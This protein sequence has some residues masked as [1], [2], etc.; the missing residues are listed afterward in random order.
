MCR[1]CHQKTWPH[2]YHFCLSQPS[3]LIC[4]VCE[5]EF[6]AEF[7]RYRVHMRT[8]TGANPY[9]C[10]A[11]GC[12]KAYISRQL[13]WKHQIRRHPEIAANASKA[14]LEKRNKREIAKF[15]AKSLENIQLCRALVEDLLKSVIVD[16]AKPEADE[17]KPEE[18]EDTCKI[19]E[20][21]ENQDERP[22]TPPP[23]L[24][25]SL[26]ESETIEEYDPIDA[27][28]R[29]IM[30]PEGT[31]RSNRSPSK[32]PLSPS[33]NDFLRPPPVYAPTDISEPP[34]LVVNTQSPIVQL[35][36]NFIRGPLPGL[37]RP[38]SVNIVR[39]GPV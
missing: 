4:E 29:S 12:Q 15:G 1:S 36:P 32:T 13:L 20:N 14:L 30:G 17:K 25:E 31:I 11:K 22:L 24:E 16:E 9:L 6:G 28:V 2:V 27:A 34:Q 37:I 10:S 18:V 26:K 35:R 23:Q 5:T 38:N 8:H 3:D 39:P 7:K 33:R 19:E 21:K